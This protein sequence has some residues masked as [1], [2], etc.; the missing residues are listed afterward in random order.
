[1]LNVLRFN[2]N[3]KTLHLGGLYGSTRM[4]CSLLPA[5]CLYAE[6]CKVSVCFIL[7]SCLV[8]PPKMETCSSETSVDIQWIKRRDI[9]QKTE[10]FRVECCSAF[11]GRPNAKSLIALR[12]VVI[13]A[14]PSEAS[15]WKMYTNASICSTIWRAYS[16][17]LG[18][19]RGTLPATC[20]SH[21]LCNTK[22]GGNT[23]LRNVSTF[24]QYYHA[25]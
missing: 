13:I 1:V 19:R 22:E 20:M 18:L 14:H 7:I 15:H 2:F 16:P 17:Y 8:S 24:I 25:I 4:T 21:L 11:H 23:L 6:L 5:S 3:F 12:P 10:L 9:S